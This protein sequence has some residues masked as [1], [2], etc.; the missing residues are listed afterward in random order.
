MVAICCRST[1]LLY[2]YLM[3]TIACSL[4][5]LATG[6]AILAQVNVLQ[7]VENLKSLDDPVEATVKVFALSV[8]SNCCGVAVVEEELV[9]DVNQP[10]EPCAADSNEEILLA[11]FDLALLEG[12]LKTCGTLTE[13]DVDGDPFVGVVPGQDDVCTAGQADFVTLFAHFTQGQFRRVGLTNFVAG[14]S[15]MFPT[16]L[17]LCLVNKTQKQERD[18]GLESL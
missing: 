11:V 2:V 3:L 17:M 8:F 13:L 4:T 1:Y 15:M 14:S 6:A 7:N 16:W 5:I 18:K 9:R 12:E 10:V